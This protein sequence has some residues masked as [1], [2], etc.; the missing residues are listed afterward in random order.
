MHPQLAD[1]SHH[2]LIVH[3]WYIHDQLIIIPPSRTSVDA[4]PIARY[5]I[6]LFPQAKLLEHAASLDSNPNT[7][8]NFT[9]FW[10]LLIDGNIGELGTVRSN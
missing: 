6:R 4:I 5:R 10:G 2:T 9:V 1:P 3:S 8:S 7:R